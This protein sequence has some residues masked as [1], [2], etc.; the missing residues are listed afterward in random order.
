MIA[1][2]QHTPERQRELLG[3]AS[4]RSGLPAGAIEKDWWVT[5]ALNALG[6]WPCI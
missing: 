5:L 1:W 3:L 6:G 4:S 2:L